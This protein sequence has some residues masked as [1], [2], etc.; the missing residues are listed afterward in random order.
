[1]GA[2]KRS[3]YLRLE[4]LKDISIA[5][6]EVERIVLELYGMLFLS[7]ERRLPGVW[8]YPIRLPIHCY[9]AR[10][11]PL[12]EGQVYKIE[13]CLDSKGKSRR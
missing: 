13:N 10:F 7:Y 6:H 4:A 9:Q 2:L 1:M 8:V 12:G 5:L 3:L 11:T